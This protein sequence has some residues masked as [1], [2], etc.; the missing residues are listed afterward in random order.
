MCDRECP[1]QKI[2]LF[3]QK[4]FPPDIP[5]RHWIWDCGYEKNRESA[6]Y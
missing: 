2:I 5:V 4:N 3:F 1:T 6:Q